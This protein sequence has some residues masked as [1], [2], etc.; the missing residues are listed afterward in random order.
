MLC[1]AFFLSDRCCLNLGCYHKSTTYWWLKRQT[2]ILHNSGAEKCKIKPLE[3]SVSSE[4]L[5]PGSLTTNVLL[6]PYMIQGVRELSKVSFMR[7]P[8]PHP[9]YL[10]TPP[11]G[12]AKSHLLVPSHWVLGSQHMNLGD[13]KYSI[14]K[15]C[16]LFS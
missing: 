10:I 13:T 7:A 14:H 12:P 9:H 11:P 16:L 15:K 5:L 8:V 2:F 4:S 1:K 3:D 6:Y